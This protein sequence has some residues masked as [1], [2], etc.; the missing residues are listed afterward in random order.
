MSNI[1]QTHSLTQR[2]HLLSPH[3]CKEPSPLCWR[4]KDSC[5][6]SMAGGR[7]GAEA[8][9][10]YHGHPGPCGMK[11]RERYPPSEVSD[12]SEER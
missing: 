2:V 10:R 9:C 11:V 5:A 4:W 7:G 6:Q 3:P 8:A 12:G 1:A